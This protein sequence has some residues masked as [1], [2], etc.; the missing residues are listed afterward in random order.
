VNRVSAALL[1]CVVWAPVRASACA[2][3]GA[4]DPSLT[5]AGTEQ[6]FGGRVR[7][8]LA[9]ASTGATTGADVLA[10]RR[11][12]LGAAWAPVSWAMF[13]ATAPVAWRELDHPTLERE[14]GVGPG[15]LDVRGR[16]VV[17]RDR[18][19][20]PTHLVTLQL[21]ARIPLAP[22][23]ADA[24]GRALSDDAQTAS[25]T[26]APLVGLAWSVYAAPF[27]LQTYAWMTVPTRGSDGTADAI[28]VRAAALGLW[29]ALSELSIVLGAETRASL[30][31]S[32]GG[33]VVFG[34]LGTLLRIGDWTP[35]LLVRIP[36]VSSFGEGRS[37]LVGLELGT[38]FDA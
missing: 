33:A 24:Q 22:A 10:E 23:L 18:A 11:L 13:S 26:V 27:S 29:Q 2:S 32:R 21:G 7:L 30:D 14:T 6:P 35:Y 31:P 36:I 8:S 15:D 25:R 3:C 28:E 16:F 38:T 5:L 37:E 17:L 4:G 20:A 1:L 34:T 19:F 12:T 9:V